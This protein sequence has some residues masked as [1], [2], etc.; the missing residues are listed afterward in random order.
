[1]FQVTQRNS[2]INVLYYP[3]VPDDLFNSRHYFKIRQVTVSCQSKSIVCPSDTSIH[4]N[5]DIKRL[6][7]VKECWQL[8]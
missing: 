2:K 3:H 6:K 1:L 4:I 7:D 5:V 8:Y